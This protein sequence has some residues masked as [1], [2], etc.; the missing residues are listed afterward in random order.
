MNIE[1]GSKIKTLRL[2]RS[3]TQEQ[4]AQTLHVSA[5]AVSKWEN[6]TS[7]PDIQLLPELSVTLGTSIDA[8][9]SLTDESRFTRIGNMIEDRRFL[10]SQEFET[11]ERFLQDKCQNAET[12]PRAVLLLAQLYCKRAQEYNGLASPLARRAL[13]LNPQCKAAHNAVFDAEGGAYLD[14]NAANRY[15]TIAFYKDFIAQHPNERSAYLWLLDLLIADGRCPE[16]R[17]Y[18]EKMRRLGESF[19]DA[20]YLGLICKA[21]GRL[22]EALAYWETMC[23]QYASQWQSWVSR[24][25]ELAKLCRYEEAVADYRKAMA[26]MPHP[27]FVDPPEAI[28]QICEICGDYSGAISSYETVIALLRED[29]N[30]TQGETIDAPQRAIVRLRELAA[31]NA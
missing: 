8:L 30:I 10:T 3:M 31:S 5:Q 18:A 17:E 4:L 11:E 22:D 23:T 16:A 25:S 6:G 12:Q 29:W 2:A 24:A 14:W 27:Q 21:E 28:A 26:L 7:M 19:N 13:M 15:R 20:L 9:F 1:I